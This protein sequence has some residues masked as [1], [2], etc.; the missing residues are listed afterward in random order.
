MAIL[1]KRP[2]ELLH[3]D[4]MGPSRTESLGGKKY[5]LVM[6]DNFTKYSWIEF[7]RENSKTLDVIKIL[8]KKFQ[9][10]QEKSIVRIRS[11]RGREFENFSLERFCDEEGISQEFSA[12][13]TL[14]QNG[15]VKKRIESFKKWLE[16]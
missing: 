15:V 6:V 5:I 9:N 14:Q 4:L 1:T 13:I 2:L 10:K 12:F 8:Y 7:L 11:D 3:I 16:L